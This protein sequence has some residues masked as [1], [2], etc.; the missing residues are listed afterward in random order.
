MPMPKPGS[1]TPTPTPSPSPGGGHPSTDDPALGTPVVLHKITKTSGCRVRGA[2]P[3]PA[4]TPGARFSKVTKAQVCV[5]GYSKRV[6]NVPQSVKNAVYRAYGI[7]KH[8]NGQNGEVDHLVSLELGGANTDDSHPTANLFPEAATPTP[9]SHQ[10]DRLE[11]LLHKR[12]CDGAMTLRAAQ[13]AIATDWLA[14]YHKL[15]LG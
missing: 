13:R 15:G 3:D 12:V 7:S 2:L 10:K 11:N 9:G 8:F 1:P 6:R 4:C 14:E 5:P